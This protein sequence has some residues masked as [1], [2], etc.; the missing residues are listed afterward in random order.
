MGIAIVTVFEMKAELPEFVAPQFAAFTD[1]FM[2]TA[3]VAGAQWAF[4]GFLTEETQ[5][6]TDPPMEVVESV[7]TYGECIE[8][9]PDSV[10][11]A[12]LETSMRSATS[13]APALANPG[14]RR[15]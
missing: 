7:P 10:V 14:E 4:T 3:P 12:E 5:P 15:G 13:V 8:T 1:A 6:P 9:V 2:L 11:P